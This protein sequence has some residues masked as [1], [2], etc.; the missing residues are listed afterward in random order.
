MA[1]VTISRDRLVGQLGQKRPKKTF[2]YSEL[3]RKAD[4]KSRDS[5]IARASPLTGGTK[6]VP[7]GGVADD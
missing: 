1:G 3:N 6:Y 4:Y 5:G 7:L 2:T